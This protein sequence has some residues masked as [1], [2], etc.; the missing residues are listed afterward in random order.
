LDPQEVFDE[1]G[2]DAVLLCWE[3]YTHFCHRFLVA[4]WF[5]EKLDI[6]VREI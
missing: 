1:L 2:E 6:E 4:D 3:P 5:K